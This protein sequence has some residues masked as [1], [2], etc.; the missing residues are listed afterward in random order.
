MRDR[1]RER[2]R[3]IEKERDKKRVIEEKEIKKRERQSYKKRNGERER[4]REREREK[5]SDSER[6][7]NIINEACKWFQICSLILICRPVRIFIK[8]SI[9]NN[10]FRCTFG[11]DLMYNKILRI[12][13]CVCGEIVYI[14]YLI[15]H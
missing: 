8:H 14:Y 10:Y 6:Q 12:K 1:E 11:S 15:T 13:I 5:E 9:E 7:L 3:E 4:E 2:K